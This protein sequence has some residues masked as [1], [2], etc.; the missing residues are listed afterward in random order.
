MAVVKLQIAFK[1]L[2]FTFYVSC[3]RQPWLSGT[4]FKLKG[5]SSVLMW[6]SFRISHTSISYWYAAVQCNISLIF[7]AIL[8]MLTTLCRILYYI[9]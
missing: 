8:L 7:L 6:Y 5:L 1:N 9:F 4:L 3:I 2:R